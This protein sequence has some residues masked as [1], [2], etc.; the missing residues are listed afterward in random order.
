MR[1]ERDESGV[2][3]AERH[4][5]ENGPV[6]WAP[7]A[8]EKLRDPVEERQREREAGV[9]HGHVH[10]DADVGV[11]RQRR[12]SGSGEWWRVRVGFGFGVRVGIGIGICGVVFSFAA[13]TVFRGRRSFGGV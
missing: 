2:E 10:C 6:D 7:V 12:R 8:F 11:G 5:T 9:G 13:A 3:L 1:P 4:R